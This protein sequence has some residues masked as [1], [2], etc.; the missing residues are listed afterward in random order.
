MAVAKAKAAQL[1]QRNR[2]AL[3]KVKPSIPDCAASQER[4]KAEEQEA[5]KAAAEAKAAQLQLLQQNRQALLKVKP[6]I[7]AAER[8]KADERCSESSRQ[9][10]IVLPHRR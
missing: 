9:F 4:R 6:S 10:L 3:F 2:R 1:L 5:A 8:R 7:P